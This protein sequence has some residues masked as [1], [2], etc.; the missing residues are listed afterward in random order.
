VVTASHEVREASVFRFLAALVGDLTTV[1]DLSQLV[2]RTLE[3]LRREVGFHSATIALTDDHDP[4]V[5]RIVGS[6]GL[7]RALHGTETSRPSGYAWR[8]VTARRP[9]YLPDTCGRHGGSPCIRSSVYA[10]LLADGEAIGALAVHAPFVGAFSAD[11]VARL[12][13]LGEYAGRMFAIVRLQHRLRSLANTDPLTDLPNRRHFL[14][15]L[16]RE[17]ARCH[18][19]AAP[20]AVALI[21]LDGFKQLNDAHG[22]AAGDMALV[23]VARILESR[24]RAS[25]VLARFGGDEFAMLLRDTDHRTPAVLRDLSAAPLRL[26]LRVGECALSVS[27]GAA[28]RPT[29]G[30]SPEALL[31]TADV[32]LYAMKRLRS[33]GRRPRHEPAAFGTTR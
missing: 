22:H 23:Q 32:R 5:L 24:V 19:T 30:E 20:L 1:R 21:D 13:T 17:L 10:P 16:D 14:S 4:N 33:A 26:G 12:S 18:R 31:R 8:A 7:G 28:S 9:L 25:D 11:D 2:E 15:E 6:A 27:W 29:D 3:G